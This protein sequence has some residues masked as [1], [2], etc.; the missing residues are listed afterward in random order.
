MQLMSK[1]G[2]R[3]AAEKV[4]EARRD[5]R[6]VVELVQVLEV[7]LIA[8]LEVLRNELRLAH[9]ARFTIDALIVHACEKREVQTFMT[10]QI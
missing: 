1:Q 6:D 7:K 4:L 5:G 8:S 3:Q 9:S 10:V 2:D